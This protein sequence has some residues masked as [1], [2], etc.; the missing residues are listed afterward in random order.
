MSALQ[1]RE[2]ASSTKPKKPDS[3]CWS[4]E[5]T[6]SNFADVRVPF[7]PPGGAFKLRYLIYRPRIASCDTAHRGLGSNPMDQRR[8][9]EQRLAARISTTDFRGG[10]LSRPAMEKASGSGSAMPTSTPSVLLRKA[11]AGFCEGKLIDSIQSIAGLRLRSFRQGRFWEGTVPFSG[12]YFYQRPRRS[13]APSPE[14]PPPLHHDGRSRGYCR[15]SRLVD[16][17]TTVEPQIS[18]EG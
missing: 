9:H 3:T 1:P 11:F 18:R 14:S 2:M 13:N 16:V 15:G 8:R 12:G 5:P 6:R 7:H 10:I 17:G 4:P